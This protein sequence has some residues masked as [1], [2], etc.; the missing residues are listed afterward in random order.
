MSST[1]TSTVKSRDVVD[2][3]LEQDCFYNHQDTPYQFRHLAGQLQASMEPSKPDGLVGQPGLTTTTLPR[4]KIILEP[5][6]DHETYTIPT[7]PVVSSALVFPF[8]GQTQSRRLPSE[9]IDIGSCNILTQWLPLI[10]VSTESDEGLEFPSTVS[11]WQA[12][13]LRELEGDESIPSEHDLGLTHDQDIQKK[14]HTPKQIREIFSLNDHR[15]EC[16]EPVSAPLSPASDL[17]EP[18]VPGT[19]QI[20]ID[21][22]SEPS[23]P[24]NHPFEK[25]Q[26][27]IQ[28]GYVDSEP[29]ASS[30][31]PSSPPT[32]RVAFLS[33]ASNKPSD[34]KL[35]TPMLPSSSETNVI[36]DGL[37]AARGPKLLDSNEA[38]QSPVEQ[39]SFFEEALQV[40]LD[41]KHHQTNQ[42]IEEERLNPS[43]TFQMATTNITGNV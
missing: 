5:L 32:A 14:V 27:N 15:R 42:Q 9:S 4:T 38:R 7:D 31:M 8:L 37:S 3:A 12:L 2:Y 19:Q 43:G 36:S 1:T 16:L 25:L 23:S 28:H 18:F 24:I 39:G 10:Y 13:A 26:W 22:T 41:G 29:A 11:R 33:T 20:V 35:D 17:D 40:I 21:L 30:T 6:L 34:L